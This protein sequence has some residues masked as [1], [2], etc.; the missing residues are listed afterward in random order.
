MHHLSALDALFLQLESSQTPMHVGGLI[1]LQKPAKHR[2]SFLRDFRHHIE[3][4]LHLAPLFTRAV[5]LEHTLDHNGRWTPKGGI[6]QLGAHYIALDS[7]EDIY[8]ADTLN[9]RVQKLVKR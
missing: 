4:R 7:K 2:G 6:Q 5:R 1:L 8:V 3:A 9:W